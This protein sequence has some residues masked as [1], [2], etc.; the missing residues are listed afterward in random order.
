MSELSTSSNVGDDDQQQL[1]I[2]AEATASM[3]VGV[4]QPVGE[5][6]TGAVVGSILASVQVQQPQQLHPQ[7]ASNGARVTDDLSMSTQMQLKRDLAAASISSS[8]NSIY[9]SGSAPASWRE[10]YRSCGWFNS[11]IS[12]GAAA[13]AAAATNSS[14]N[15]SISSSSSTAASA[16]AWH[17]ITNKK[18]DKQKV[19]DNCV[20]ESAAAAAPAAAATSCSSSSSN[21]SS[22]NSSRPTLKK[23]KKPP[24]WPLY[25]FHNP[26]F[27]P[28]MER[29]MFYSS[30]G[31]A[32]PAA[33]MLATEVHVTETANEASLHA[34]AEAVAEFAIGD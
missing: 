4:L 9:A 14:S 15:S 21:S 30:A 3:P 2:T 11:C 17:K 8:S 13:P 27:R 23:E 16:A 10:Y 28:R 12:A 29:L 25:E 6:T 5:S 24:S 22:I 19:S 18:I 31:A 32:A 34:I 7:T 20:A 33:A 26:S 1:Q